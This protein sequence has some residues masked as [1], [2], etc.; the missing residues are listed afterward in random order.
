MQVQEADEAA[1]EEFEEVEE[2]AEEEAEEEEEGDEE[3]EGDDAKTRCTL[4]LGNSSFR[5]ER[6]A[7]WRWFRWSWSAGPTP[8]GYRTTSGTFR[9]T[10]PSRHGR[11]SRL[12]ATSSS[13]TRTRSFTGMEPGCFPFRRR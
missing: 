12:C 7:P 1:E 6:T 3:R 8:S 4:L 2:K 11:H 9:C 5:I 10:R 13:E